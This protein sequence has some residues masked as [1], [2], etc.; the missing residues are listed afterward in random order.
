MHILFKL[1]KKGKN[2]E[3]ARGGNKHL[4]QREAKVKIV[5]DFS[6]EK[7]HKQEESGVKFLRCWDKKATNLE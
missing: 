4:P 7:L 5:S 2:P 3:E 6:L 1:Q